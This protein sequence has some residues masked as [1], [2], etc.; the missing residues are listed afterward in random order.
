MTEWDWEARS[1]EFWQDYQDSDKD[2]V[3][4]LDAV[5][6]EFKDRVLSVQDVAGLNPLHP[7]TRLLLETIRQLVPAS[8]ADFGYGFGDILYNVGLLLPDAELYGYDIAAHKMECVRERSPSLADRA[9]LQ[10]R[11]IAL[12]GEFTEVELTYTSVVIMHILGDR[13]LA[14]LRN[15]FETATEHVVLMEN[16]NTHNFMEDIRRLHNDFTLFKWL[17]LYFYYRY[18]P[19]FARPHL[20]IVSKNNNLPYERLYDYDATMCQ[21]LAKAKREGRP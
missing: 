3:R 20:M 5:S 10:Q 17:E 21:P 12:P 18:S 6:W 9:V 14:A 8:V 13:R 16:W 1:E 2:N 4:K 19:E 7:N 11:D 15:V